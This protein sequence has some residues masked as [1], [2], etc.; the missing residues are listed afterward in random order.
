M[1]TSSR[2]AVQRPAIVWGACEDVH[3]SPDLWWSLHVPGWT[4]ICRCSQSFCI[5]RWMA[6]PPKSLPRR[7]QR[8]FG[9]ARRQLKRMKGWPNSSDSQQTLY[10]AVLQQHR[11]CLMFFSSKSCAAVDALCENLHLAC[12]FT[13]S[14]RTVPVSVI[15]STCTFVRVSFACL[16]PV[17]VP[18]RGLCCE[19]SV[20]SCRGN[21]IVLGTAG[22]DSIDQ[23]CSVVSKTLSSEKCID[24]PKCARL[25]G[26]LVQSAYQGCKRDWPHDKSCKQ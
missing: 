3:V 14:H 21:H 17:F 24:C 10:D 4:R 12:G 16:A 1:L 20:S 11:W 2:C 7:V 5:W 23:S 19:A 26:G 8:N 13:F 22:I 15:F 18:E 9:F 25:V 6:C